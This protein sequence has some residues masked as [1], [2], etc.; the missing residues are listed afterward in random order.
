MTQKYGWGDDQASPSEIVGV[1]KTDE[2]GLH[3]SGTIKE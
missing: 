1:E 2:Q 3:T